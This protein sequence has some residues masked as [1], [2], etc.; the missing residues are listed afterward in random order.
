MGGMIEQCIGLERIVVEHKMGGIALA[1]KQSPRGG[2]F[3]VE[4]L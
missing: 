3:S 4:L 1:Y 2:S